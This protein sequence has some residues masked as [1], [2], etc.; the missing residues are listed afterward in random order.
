MIW[1]ISLLASNRLDD[2]VVQKSPLIPWLVHVYTEYSIDRLNSIRIHGALLYS[3][4]F[5]WQACF[6]GALYI[7]VYKSSLDRFNLRLYMAR[8]EKMSGY[9]DNYP[10]LALRD[11]HVFT[12]NNNRVSSSNLHVMIIVHLVFIV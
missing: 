8:H 11:K 10:L 7:Y 6:K 3:E 9:C 2:Y 12:A 5:C 4:Y 1:A